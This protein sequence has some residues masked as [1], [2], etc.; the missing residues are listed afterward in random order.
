MPT[1]NVT[2]PAQRRV[3]F[4]DPT[5]QALGLEQEIMAAVGGVIG[6]GD[7]I[8]GK[9]VDRLEEEFAAYCGVA[10]AVGVDSGV[11]ALGL[12]LRAA[13]VGPGD[14][15]VTQANTF[16]AT[17]GAVIAVGAVPVLVDCDPEGGPDVEAFRA[18]ITPATKAIIP[19]H[20]FGLLADMEPFAALAAE[21]GLVLVEDACQAHGARLAGRRAGSWGTASAFSV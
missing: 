5:P 20:L 2:T 1:T 12:S 6:R 9:D 8:L 13:G 15:V 11:S 21:R 10:H 18:R 7:F 14:E 19:V 3:R 17:V 16:I 4:M